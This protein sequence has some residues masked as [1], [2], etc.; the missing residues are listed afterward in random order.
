MILKLAQPTFMS[1]L[2]A[3]DADQTLHHVF[4]MYCTVYSICVA[5]CIAS[6]TAYIVYNIMYRIMYSI[7]YSMHSNAITMCQK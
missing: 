3:Y 4:F 1:W 2:Y 5:L 6:C 7:M